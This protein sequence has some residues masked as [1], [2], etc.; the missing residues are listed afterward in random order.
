MAD[1]QMIEEVL[2]FA[3]DKEIEAE[4][5][6]TYWAGKV[7]KPWIKT[8]FEGYAAEEARHAVKLREVKAGGGAGKFVD[9]QERVA[10]LKLSDYLVDMSATPDM[11]YQDALIV[12]MKREKAAFRLYQD[13][14]AQV[15]DQQVKLLFNALANEEAKHKLKLETM[16]DDLL[17]PEN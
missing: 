8:V 11:D 6:Y 12:G 10:D 5:F 17:A 2:D 14:A 7:D 9:S 4:Q 16:Y 1:S 15:A 3:I 13:L